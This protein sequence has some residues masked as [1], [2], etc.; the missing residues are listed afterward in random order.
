M[1]TIIKT[2]LVAVTVL[3]SVNVAAK[4]IKLPAGI[5]YVNSTDE[6][7]C[8]E[9]DGLH[10]QTKNLFKYKGNRYVFVIELGGAW[11]YDNPMSVLNL[12]TWKAQ[13]LEYND[14][15]LCSGNN[16]PFFEIKN[17]VPTVGIIDTS[18]KPVIV[19]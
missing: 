11:C 16:E 4:T 7:Y 9:I 17:G 12:E 1:K 19:A 15:R 5:K 10:C 6:F 18:E 8:T 14:K 3:F 13:R 2:L